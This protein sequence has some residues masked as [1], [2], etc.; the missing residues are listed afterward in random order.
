MEYT[1]DA[2]HEIIAEMVMD[3]TGPVNFEQNI[4][5]SRLQEQVNGFKGEDCYKNK[6]TKKLRKYYASLDDS[7]DEGAGCAS[8]VANTEL[9]KLQVEH[10]AL[11]T[12]YTVDTDLLKRQKST[13]FLENVK[14]KA[15]IKKLKENNVERERKRRKIYEN[16]TETCDNKTEDH[17]R[18]DALIE[19]R[20]NFMT[21]D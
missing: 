18:Q 14:L 16:K 9:K 6:L 13:L 4:L 5:R 20:N 7:D 8:Y 11:R 2:R 21:D 19:L 10:R 3:T 1:L 17:K 12:K 15:G